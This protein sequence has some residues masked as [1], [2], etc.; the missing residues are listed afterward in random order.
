MSTHWDEFSKS[1]A[2]PVPRRESLRQL[3]AIFAAAA[4]AP[5]GTAFGRGRSPKPQDPC[6]AFCKCSNKKAQNQCL[7]ACKACNQDPS[8]LTGSCGNYA[9]CSNGQYSCGGFCA[10]LN[11]DPSNCGACGYVCAEPGPNEYGYCLDGNCEY[12]CD[13]AAVYC[14]GT[15]TFLG[16][17]PLNCGSCGNV[18]PSSAP[19]CEQGVCTNTAPCPIG[20]MRCSGV[21]TDVIS[22]NANCG[23]CGNVCPDGFACSGGA[24]VD[25]VCQF[26]EC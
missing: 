2:Q 14:N 17:D 26:V 13:V 24:C 10:D 18:C 22:D 23:G 19:Y 9:C 8:R 11:N 16:S 15:C 12:A 25:P 21:C 3:G 5:L 1:L 20:E 7:S 6:A 4:L